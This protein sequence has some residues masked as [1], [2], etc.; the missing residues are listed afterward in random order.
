MNEKTKIEALVNA[1]TTPHTFVYERANKANIDLDEATFP[2][3]LMFEPTTGSIDDLLYQLQD[4][5]VV[6]LQFLDRIEDI[7]DDAETNDTIF[8]AEKT[9]LM[10]F[11]KRYNASGYFER[12][13]NWTWDKITERSYNVGA[14]GF[15]ITFEPVLRVGTSNCV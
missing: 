13:D 9:A 12:K 5:P 1:M 10:D 15:S 8:T 7:E 2:V 3:V 11:I 14:I 6:T 4:K